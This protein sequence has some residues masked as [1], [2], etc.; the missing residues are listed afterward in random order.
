[1]F[2]FRCLEEETREKWILYVRG[3]KER[4]RTFDSKRENR[5]SV[6]K[7]KVAK[8]RKGEPLYRTIVARNEIRL[9]PAEN[10]VREG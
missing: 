9:N 8:S 5:R 1:M 2:R 7:I 3:E 10:R 4:A 6:H